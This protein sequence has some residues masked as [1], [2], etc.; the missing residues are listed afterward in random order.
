MK[1]ILPFFVLIAFTSQLIAQSPISIDPLLVEIHR[2]DA[3][4]TNNSLDIVEKYEVTNISDETV[5]LIWVLEIDE[6]CAGEWDMQVCDNN[7]C[8]FF[9]VV[10]N[11]AEN[12]PAASLD[13]GE[14]SDL[15]SLHVWP[16]LTSGC[17]LMYMHYFLEGNLQDTLATVTFDVRINDFSCAD[18]SNIEEEELSTLRVFPNPV[19]D[20][21]FLEGNESQVVDQLVIY[22]VLGKPVRQFNTMNQTRFELGDLPNGT[23]FVSMLDS[24]G[25]LLKTTR[26]NRH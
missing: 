8:Y 18:V 26:L 10:D 4:L 5:N 6:S 17:C 25:Q 9:G 24:S 20:Y 19:T 22:D 13:P 7:L 14:S 11:I 16:R 1:N 15:F 21:F 3:D 2:E 23:Y 12:I